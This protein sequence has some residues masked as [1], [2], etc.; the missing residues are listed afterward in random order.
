MKT[1]SFIL[2]SL[3]IAIPMCIFK[4]SYFLLKDCP[5]GFLYGESYICAKPSHTDIKKKK[6]KTPSYTH[7][8]LICTQFFER[9]FP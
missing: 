1:L 3:L 4:D 6:K 2:E 5:R 7:M 8:G 9:K